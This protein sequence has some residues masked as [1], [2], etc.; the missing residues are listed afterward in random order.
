MAQP[1]PSTHA[2]T[3]ARTHSLV[4]ETEWGHD[5]VDERGE[6]GELGVAEGVVPEGHAHDA[7]CVWVGV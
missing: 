5:V 6:A 3:H 7:Y 2:R 4:G 1:N